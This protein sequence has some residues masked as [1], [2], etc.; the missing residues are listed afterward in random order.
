MSEL[1]YIRRG[2]VLVTSRGAVVKRPRILPQDRYQVSAPDGSRY[3]VFIRAGWLWRLFHQRRWR[4]MSG[5]RAW[6]QEYDAWVW[7]ES[8]CI[9]R[10]VDDD[11]H[12]VGYARWMQRQTYAAP[13]EDD[14][15]S[16]PFASLY[17]GEPSWVSALYENGLPD[18]EHAPE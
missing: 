8:Q 1:T 4:C 3:Q 13:S 14:Y 12:G 18:W 6:V 15:L 16:W 2:A 9:N 7:L 17:T 10:L 5:Q 11:W